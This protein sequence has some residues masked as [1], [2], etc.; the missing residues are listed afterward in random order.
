MYRPLHRNLNSNWK[1]FGKKQKNLL[2]RIYKLIKYKQL[3][4]KRFIKK[5]F[6]LDN[7]FN[8]YF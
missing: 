7:F 5:P 1:S 6:I 8:V 4:N 2:G 3:T